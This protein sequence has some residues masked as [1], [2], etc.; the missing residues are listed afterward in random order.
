MNSFGNV[1]TYFSEHPHRNIGPTLSQN[2]RGPPIRGQH[3]SNIQLSHRITAHGHGPQWST[4]RPGA[5]RSAP[6]N[7]DAMYLVR[8]TTPLASTFE[9]KARRWTRW[10]NSAIL[11]PL[12]LRTE[13]AQLQSTT[14]SGKP[15]SDSTKA[16]SFGAC[17]AKHGKREP[18]SSD[19]SCSTHFSM[20]VN[21]GP[22]AQQ[23]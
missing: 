12:S 14:V 3:G 9:S 21:A 4:L 8:T 10:G 11:A 16:L 5:S 22:S 1:A 13:R 17:A 19:V 6:R 15:G 20:D 2:D 23:T 18:P 7:Q